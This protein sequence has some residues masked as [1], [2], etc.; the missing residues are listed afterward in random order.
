MALAEAVVPP[1]VMIRPPSSLQLIQPPPTA[2]AVED[3]ENSS[4]REFDRESQASVDGNYP[5]P[6]AA[7]VTPVTTVS[8]TIRRDSTA[9]MTNSTAPSGVGGGGGHNTTITRART[10]SSSGT[11]V[12]GSSSSS[13]KKPINQ[14]IGITAYNQKYVKYDHISAK[15]F[16]Y[17]PDAKVIFSCGHWDWSVRVTSV[18]S[19][20]LL[21]S[22]TGHNDVVNC[23]AIA[24]DYGNKWLITGSRDCTLITWDIHLDRT[25]S[26]TV[27]PLRTLYGHDDAINCIVVNPEL[28]MILSGSDDGTMIVHNLRD[29]KYIRSILN[30]D[31]SHHS[32]SGSGIGGG[33]SG[34][35][36][37]QKALQ[38]SASMEDLLSVD[39]QQQAVV[40]VQAHH[41]SSS[42]T[43]TV[44][45]MWNTPGGLQTPRPVNPAHT[46]HSYAGGMMTP[47]VD[48]EPIISGLSTP[49]ASYASLPGTQ[50][51]PAIR[52][53]PPLGEGSGGGSSNVISGSAAG[54]ALP[55]V[56]KYN[57]S[58]GWKVTWLG[59]SREGYVITYS[60]EQQRL[61]TFSLNGDFICSKKLS[62]ALYSFLLSEDGLVL[63]TG[64]SAGLVVF[65]WVRKETDFS[66]CFC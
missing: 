33:V 63:L 65:R 24:K 11:A 6:L 38:P 49:S 21:H 51:F 64:G 35:S 59:V 22:L 50:L 42:T 34:G 32:S 66:F 56:S 4:H 52:S 45:A 58:T 23:I 28:D 13:V 31:S 8:T 25:N 10:Y 29:G 18:E 2:T 53:P 27:T 43:T 36:G 30:I 41:S 47:V 55:S 1:P 61:A 20:K 19:G 62:E 7:A 14:V 9:S 48:D 39:P 44:A 3:A 5:P 57:R 15:N 37:R 26:L 46:H 60:A 17:L 12:G 40:A 16:A 54:G